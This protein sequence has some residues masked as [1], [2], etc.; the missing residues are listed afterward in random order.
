MKPAVLIVL[1]CFDGDVK[2][3]T[4][5]AVLNFARDPNISVQIR[6][7]GL[8]VVRVRSRAVR[9]FLSMRNRAGQLLTHLF[10]VDAD[11]SFSPDIPGALLASGKDLIC[12][13]YPK[14]KMSLHPLI[15]GE[16]PEL[17]AGGAYEWP[18]I[19]LPGE[20][21]EMEVLKVSS[22]PMGCTMI[23]RALLETMTAH[24]GTDEHN[25]T[26]LDSDEQETV[27]LFNLILKNKR[28]YPE[29]FSF[30]ERAKECGVHP[31]LLLRPTDHTGSFTFP[32]DLLGAATAEEAS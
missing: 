22:I 26:F 15:L 28:L 20:V 10:F 8:D 14:K 29:D 18:F 12:A 25:L 17:R 27:A 31:H 13:P 3:P 21:P 6:W 19:R 9:E 23:S 7:W 30:C 16:T 11:V 4:M 5:N 2:V 1:P 32:G 24:Y